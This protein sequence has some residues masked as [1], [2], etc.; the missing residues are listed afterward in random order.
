MAGPS[1]EA[2]QQKK[3]LLSG[4]EWQNLERMQRCGTGDSEGIV[5]LA[6]SKVIQHSGHNGIPSPCCWKCGSEKC[7]SAL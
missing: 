2:L 6:E 7:C 5:I 1:G 4:L 3:T